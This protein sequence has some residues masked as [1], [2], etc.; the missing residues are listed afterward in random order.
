MG[1]DGDGAV[2]SSHDNAYFFEAFGEVDFKFFSEVI[3]ES[4]FDDGLI[5][6]SIYD[7][8]MLFFGYIWAFELVGFDYD[9]FGFAKDGCWSAIGDLFFLCDF[10]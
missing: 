7:Y 2:V 1:A 10:F 5:L 6:R 9:G 3:F 8:F 4:F